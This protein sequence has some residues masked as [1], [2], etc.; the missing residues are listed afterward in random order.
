MNEYIILR[1]NNSLN[2][3]N[4]NMLKQLF[5]LLK[6]YA[7]KSLSNLLNFRDYYKSLIES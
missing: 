5:E 6:K 1:E 7:E 2:T 4:A 3:H